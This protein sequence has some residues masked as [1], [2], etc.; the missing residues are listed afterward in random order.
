MILDRIMDLLAALALVIL[1]LAPGV[2]VGFFLWG[3]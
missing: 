2:L 3:L 1:L